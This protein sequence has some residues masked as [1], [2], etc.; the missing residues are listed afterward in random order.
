MAQ[1]AILLDRDG[2]INVN[3]PDDVKSW[4]EFE[5]IPGSLQAISELTNLGW[6]IVVLTNQ[7]A[8]AQGTL[9]VQGL[10]RIH[11]HMQ[12]SV[13][14]AGG[15][16]TR[17]FSCACAEQG[18][19]CPC[20]KPKPF[21]LL[22]AKRELDLDLE[23]SYLIGDKAT[24][25]EFGKRGK[26]KTV[27]VLTGEGCGPRGVWALGSIE[28]DCIQRDLAHAARWIIQQELSQG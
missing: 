19:N 5:W 9:T 14:Q 23:R 8:I 10:E 6:P 1:P 21:M 27:L 17:I 11:Q 24:D 18:R 25:I 15:R 22:Q 28:P 12:E 13:E 20:E 3:R 7:R 2:V 16:I 4:E 26:T